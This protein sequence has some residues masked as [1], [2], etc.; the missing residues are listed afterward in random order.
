[1]LLAAAARLLLLGGC[2]LPRPAT[3]ASPS[4]SMTT[5]AV[6]FNAAAWRRAA[7][8]EELPSF[9][10][11]A[12]LRGLLDGDLTANEANHAAW[13]GLGYTVD[14]DGDVRS[15][16][17]V[18]CLANSLPDVLNDDTQIED[19]RQQLPTDEDEMGM[20]DTLVESLH[21]E[22]LTRTLIQEGDR[23]FLSRRTL[24]QW[25]YLSQPELHL[26]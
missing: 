18:P 9:D 13:R 4:V 25:L 6:R 11:M 7:C 14:A 10:R 2:G 21:G 17:G 15:P 20:L 26:K 19:F 3:R 22:E 12:L 1:M 8:W 16:D 24:V 23:D 5:P